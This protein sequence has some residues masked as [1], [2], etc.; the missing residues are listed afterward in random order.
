MSHDIFF[1]KDL[2]HIIDVS[3]L[4]HN[5]K[6][7]LNPNNLNIFYA[8]L[9][10]QTPT[11]SLMIIPKPHTIEY[12]T[13]CRPFLEK[14]IE[15]KEKPFILIG[16]KFQLIE[17]DKETLLSGRKTRIIDVTKKLNDPIYYFRSNWSDSV[18][19]LTY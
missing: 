11:E 3:V 4:K 19:W 15:V 18:L 10:Y 1:T 14:G 17:V 8:S 9:S 2:T 7:F 16:P 5:P 12:S 6:V 13:Y